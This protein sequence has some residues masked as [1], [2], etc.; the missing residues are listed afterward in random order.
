MTTWSGLSSSPHRLISPAMRR[1]ASQDAR[2]RGKVYICAR[3]LEGPPSPPPPSAL[4][5]S[6]AWRAVRK[7]YVVKICILQAGYALVVR[8][9]AWCDV[10][11]AC[12]WAERWDVPPLPIDPTLPFCVEEGKGNSL[13][14][15]GHESRRRLM[16]GA[17]EKRGR[18]FR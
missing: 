10:G 14:P 7:L 13:P 4:L 5:S 6:L 2:P 11:G 1:L 18:R 16:S 8:V 17:G 15:L 12:V 9:T 3:G